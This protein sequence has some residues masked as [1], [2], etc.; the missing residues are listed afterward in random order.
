M[1]TI[2]LIRHGENTFVGEGKLAGWLP[3]VH[4]NERGKIQAA[5]LA[6]ALKPIKLR[7]VY[8]SPLERAVETATPLAA[9]KSLQVVVREGLGEIHYGR[10]QGRSIKALQKRKLWSVVQMIPSLA[11]FPDGESFS[12]AQAR[13]VA[14]LEA[15]RA[16]HHTQKS[17]IA[18]VFHSD[19]IKLAIA[20]YIGLP[21][22][23]FQ[24]LTVEPASISVLHID[25]RHTRLISL[26]DTRATIAGLRG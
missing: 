5:A 23:L 12:E 10:W 4:L 3:G 26:N 22:D 1:T 7:A 17:V 21:L 18:C 14:E 11:R 16:L 19:P 15:L 25:K 13:I 9:S 24:R 20:H 6:E 2:L 8:A